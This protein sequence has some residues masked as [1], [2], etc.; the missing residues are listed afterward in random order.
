MAA[1]G[2]AEDEI[3]VGRVVL[4]FAQLGR[5]REDDGYRCSEGFRWTVDVME[6]ECLISEPAAI[7]RSSWTAF[8]DIDG[9][10]R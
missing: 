1:L 8:F 9:E 6:T 4:A 7:R 3:V 10:R 5:H 2:A